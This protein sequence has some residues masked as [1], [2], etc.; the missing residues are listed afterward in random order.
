MIKEYIDK[1]KGKIAFVLGAGSSLKDIPLNILKKHVVVAVNRSILKVP[2]AQYC[3]SCDTGFVLWSPWEFLKGLD[4]KLL[5]NASPGAGSFHQY[6][7]AMGLDA[8]AGIDKSRVVHFVMENKLV[9]DK[10][11]GTLIRGT[12]SVHSGVHFAH[13]MGCS[14]IVLLGCDCDYTDEH[15]YFTDYP[16]EPNCNFTRPEYAKLRKDFSG[17]RYGNS[18]GELMGHFTSWGRIRVLNPDINIINASG[19]CLEAFP[20]MTVE[21]IVAQHS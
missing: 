3:L 14:P 10:E 17:A 16:S 4:C 2:F 5:L 20:R 13:L 8:F 12:S 19:G 7:T 1:H 21:E 9:M 18:D 6:D 11:S 15:K